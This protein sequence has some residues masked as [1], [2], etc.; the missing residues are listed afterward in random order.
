M[1]WLRCLL[2]LLLPMALLPL[3][4]QAQLAQTLRL[5]IPASPTETESFDVL[6][7]TDKAVLVSIQ[8]GGFPDNTPPRY[9]F[10]KYD[11]QLRPIWAR[12]I[13]LPKLFRP[14]L[15]YSDA[16]YS[17]QLLREL[18]S[19]HFQV[20][21]LHTDDGQIDS[22]DGTLVEQMS[23]EQFKV[24][25]N[26]AYIGGYFHNRPIVLTFSFFDRSIR[27]LPSLYANHLE[28]SSLEVDPINMEVN[29]LVHTVKQHCR[30]S[31]QTYNYDSRLVRTVHFDGKENSLVSGKLLPINEHETL[32]IGNYSADC[33]PY[34]QGIYVTRLRRD[35]SGEPD[36]DVP[37]TST[38]TGNIQ[39]IEFS[40]F[41]S[42]FNFLPPK[43]QQK[44]L[45]RLMHRK[46][47]GKN[48]RFRYRMLVHDLQPSPTGLT[49]VAEVYYPQYR[50][51]TLPGNMRNV[52]RL[53]GYRY[54]HA[55]VCGFDATGQLLWDNCLPINDLLSRDLT[56]KVQLS[57]QGDRIV[58]AYPTDGTIHTEVIEGRTVVQKPASVRLLTTNGDAERIVYSG[59]SELMPWYDRHFLA[60]GFQKIAPR[61]N[62]ALQREVFYINKLSYDTNLH[63]PLLR[64]ATSR[65]T[66]GSER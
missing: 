11:S 65:K 25:G 64:N 14:V 50:S 62:M 57:Q 40:Q 39:Y 59:H 29:V 56:S 23:I 7:L 44:I 49:L 24:L 22:F 30:F 20:V 18:D 51:S 1:K 36:R 66:V 28:I 46:A 2:C 3:S 10:L 27:V 60:F 9:R 61:D 52:D 41:E 6:P 53:E 17:Y 37:G 34:S 4:L 19:N 21:R 58:L 43:R 32:L 8:S 5:E 48:N 15:M 42:F 26:Q 63:L 35:D 55:F 47:L 38:H 13:Q 33:T 31:I 54:T 16:Q 12:D 45:A